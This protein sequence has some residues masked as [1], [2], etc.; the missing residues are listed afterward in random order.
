[1]REEGSRE[2]NWS[3]IPIAARILQR[4]AVVV[5]IDLCSPIDSCTQLDELRSVTVGDGE[6]GCHHQP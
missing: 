6:Q 2:G 1:M 3:P 4:K 5:D